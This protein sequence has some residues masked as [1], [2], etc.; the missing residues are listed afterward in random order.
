MS[1]LARHLPLALRHGRAPVRQ[2]SCGHQPKPPRYRP[3]LEPWQR[4]PARRHSPQWWSVHWPSGRLCPASRRQ[5]G[6]R[7]HRLRHWRPLLLWP[8][9]AWF[10][11]W[12][13]KGRPSG[14]T[15]VRGFGH[16]PRPCPRP[17]GKPCRLQ[18]TRLARQSV[19]CASGCPQTCPLHCLARSPG[20]GPGQRGLAL[21]TASRPC[22]VT[23]IPL[24]ARLQ[25]ARFRWVPE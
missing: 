7:R 17:S 8:P 12:H 18:L 6:P 22:R 19:R 24:F 25:A 23:P 14:P 13:G 9:L 15:A 4:H 5:S 2:M 11:P 10:V 16:P 21:Q 20:S 3:G 1:P